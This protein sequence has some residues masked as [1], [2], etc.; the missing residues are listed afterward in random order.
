M[1]AIAALGRTMPLAPTIAGAPAATPGEFRAFCRRPVRVLQ[2]FAGGLCQPNAYIGVPGKSVA[3]CR[4][5]ASGAIAFAVGLRRSHRSPRYNI[6]ALT[7]PHGAVATL[8]DHPFV[9]QLAGRGRGGYGSAELRLLLGAGLVRPARLPPRGC[10]AGGSVAALLR[11]VGDV[12]GGV[13]LA[14]L[15]LH[16][17]EQGN[18]PQLDQLDA[19]EMRLGWRLPGPGRLPG[20]APALGRRRAA[21]VVA[22][23]RALET[24]RH[25]AR[26]RQPRVPARKP[27]RAALEQLQLRALARHTA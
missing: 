25:R 7:R 3:A 12:V 9:G 26:G 6:A 24:N 11:C 15:G 18:L 22:G 17:V 16:A 20:T 27:G 1:H 23:T 5:A 10:G 14:G 4:T 21:V 2:R 8:G 13:V 19:T